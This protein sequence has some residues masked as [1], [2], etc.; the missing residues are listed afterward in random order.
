MCVIL[1]IDYIHVYN[2]INTLSYR[3]HIVENIAALGS[4]WMLLVTMNH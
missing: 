4:Y 2:I 1:Y 3:I